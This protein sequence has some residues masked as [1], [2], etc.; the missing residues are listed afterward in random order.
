MLHDI[1][2]IAG[3][4]T[5]KLPDTALCDDTTEYFELRYAL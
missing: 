3:Y 1:N 4:D 5:R 2:L